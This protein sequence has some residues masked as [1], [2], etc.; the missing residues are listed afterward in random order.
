M[1]K[2]IK[3][4]IRDLF[5]RQPG[6]NLTFY[7]VGKIVQ[8]R[9]APGARIRKYLTELVAEGSLR[10]ASYNPTQYVLDRNMHAYLMC[11]RNGCPNE[12]VIFYG[13]YSS[14]HRQYSH[15]YVCKRHSESFNVRRDY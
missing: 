10:I 3:S 15:I 12:A 13:T 6:V 9:S 7:K 8:P 2:S 14:L 11:V 4:E 1:R 5:E